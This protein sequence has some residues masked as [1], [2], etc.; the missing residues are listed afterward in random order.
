MR[1]A[2]TFQAEFGAALAGRT[3][4]ADAA[5]A[6]ALA[7][8]RNTATR[9]AAD[10]LADNYP[11]V[12][13]LVGNE[14]FA[15]AAV[16]HVEARPPAEPRL[17]LY[18]AGFATHVASYQPFAELPFLA[19][20]ARLERLV[21][22]AL[23]A[24]DARALAG[25]EVALDLARPLRLH[26]AARSATFG[27]PAGSIWLG[28]APDAAPD[29]IER[30]RWAPET[31]LITRPGQAV[32]VQIVPAAAAAFLDACVAGQPLGEAAVL[33]GDDLA[34]VFATLIAA[35]AFA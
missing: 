33:A 10:A 9:A 22:E 4:V 16:A 2:A 31:V 5:V 3:Q 7:I 24:A 28:H 29:A 27:T 15:A 30:I 1:D 23:F 26:P 35:G 12:R 11:V 18:G 17:C 19:D 34:G 32:R 8:H 14:A 6:R 25:D 20:V 13:A 21:V